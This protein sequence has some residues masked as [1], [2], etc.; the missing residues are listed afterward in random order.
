MFYLS[1]Y[2]FY[3]NLFYVIDSNNI[4]LKYYKLNLAIVCIYK[5]QINKIV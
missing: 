5:F 4:V 1:F 2:L 3:I